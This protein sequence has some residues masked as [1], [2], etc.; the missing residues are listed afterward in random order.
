[1]QERQRNPQVRHLGGSLGEPV[2]PV[3][4]GLDLIDAPK[5]AQPADHCEDRQHLCEVAGRRARQDG[6]GSIDCGLG[7]TARHLD[8]C[9]QRCDERLRGVIDGGFG[10]SS[11]RS[12]LAV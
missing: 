6:A 5:V 2:A 3:G 4:H 1:M 10:V 7:M 11:S 8:Q 9:S 12:A